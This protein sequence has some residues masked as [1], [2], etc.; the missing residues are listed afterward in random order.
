MKECENFKA[1]AIHQHTFM[2]FCQETRV[3]TSFDAL[4]LLLVCKSTFNYKVSFFKQ[5]FHHLKKILISGP[6]I[7]LKSFWATPYCT[8]VIMKLIESSLH[9]KQVCFVCW[10][11]SEESI[12]NVIFSVKF[13]ANHQSIFCCWRDKINKNISHKQA[14][15]MPKPSHWDPHRDLLLLEKLKPAFSSQKFALCVSIS[16]DDLWFR[17]MDCLNTRCTPSK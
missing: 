12:S 1:W 7:S 8:S 11:I 9:Y 15:L 14:S 5:H 10:S 16:A 6:E 2:T 3:S 4:L 17:Q 13:C